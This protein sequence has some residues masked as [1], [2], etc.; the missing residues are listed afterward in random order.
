M[1]CAID[2]MPM[3]HQWRK[4]LVAPLMVRLKEKDWRIECAIVL[5]SP[6][7]QW[8]NGAPAGQNET[9]LLKRI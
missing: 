5:S 2:Q 4:A 6:A 8:R 1:T 9:T 3:A 7:H